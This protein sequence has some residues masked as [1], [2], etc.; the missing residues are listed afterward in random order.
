MQISP[1]ARRQ[2][3]GLFA[4]LVVPLVAFRPAPMATAVAGTATLTY[5][6][7][8][9]AK[10]TNAGGASIFISTARGT[11]RNTG[12][13]KY[14]SAARVMNVDTAAMVNGNGSHSGHV[15]FSEGSSIVVKHFVGTTT[16]KM[17]D[18][19]P[20]SSFKGKWTI[21]RATGLYAGLTGSGTYA[22]RFETA[23]K[24]VVDWKGN[25]SK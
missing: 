17:V 3:I 6:R 16:T 12:G 18:G 19:R 13:G 10:G 21:L 23:S 4:V 11:N 22:G 8:S 7:P 15:T 24:Y 1:I 14:L 9:V 5:I 2:L 20:S 25:T